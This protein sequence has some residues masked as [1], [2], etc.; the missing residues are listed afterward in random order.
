LALEPLEP[1]L[2]LSADVFP[3][4]QANYVGASPDTLVGDGLLSEFSSGLDDVTQAIDTALTDPAFADALDIALPG[5]FDR[6]SGDDPEQWS[7]PRRSDLLDLDSA[8]TGAGFVLVDNAGDADQLN[9]MWDRNND[10]SFNFG[11][12]I[13][14]YVD[15]ILRN[16]I[17]AG[18]DLRG[19]S[20]ASSVVQIDRK[21]V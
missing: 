20:I 19:S 6:S 10:D 2:L 7:A 5:L 11:E 14:R 4:T 9:E 15:Q 12:I 8:L 18:I 1:R 21:K 16:Q 13:E 3:G 17:T